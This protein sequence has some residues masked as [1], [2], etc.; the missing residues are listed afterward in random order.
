MSRP[1]AR[2]IKS[3]FQRAL[4]CLEQFGRHEMANHAAAG[5][6]AFLLSALPAL[7]VILY[8]ASLAAGAFAL[9]A[10]GVL[11]LL[12]PYL[13][14]FGGRETLA[15]LLSRPLAGFAGAF[16]LINL[17]WAARLFIVS[18][19]RGIRV[20]Y[21]GSASI[22]PVR[23]NA[24][25]FI[26]E[27]VTLLA[28]IGLLALGQAL[29]AAQALIAWAPMKA[30]VGWLVSAGLVILPAAVLWLFVYATYRNVPPK[31]PARLNALL[32]SLLCIALYLGISAF[33][34]LF[35]DTERYGL[36]Y[37]ILGNL[38]AG[39]IKV[40]SF[41]WFYFFFAE[42]C[43]T[44]EYYDSLLFARFHRLDTADKAPNAL[45]RGLFAKPQRLFR[46][47]AKD[48]R[49]GQ[50]IFTKGQKGD[51]AFY[52]YKGSVAIYLDDPANGAAAVSRVREGEFF[53]EMASILKESRSAWALAE[54]A[55]TVFVLPAAMFERILSQDPEASRRL[56]SIMASRLLANN[57]LLCGGDGR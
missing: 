1:L 33:V 30:V 44:L 3:T 20:V 19:Q 2:V 37:G 6:Y 13:D 40:Y 15:A 53:G 43:Y 9:D 7:L 35:I 42:L 56:V 55:A 10:D 11:R 46:R 38:I 39:L 31:R 47:Y 22:N 14:A 21:A 16:G 12:G 29:R 5:A 51:E 32:S 50:A 17:I 27:L 57:D 25:T 23:E 54:E 18:I 45:E 4:F 34:G 36:L 41:F 52:L 24:L 28:A 26:L 49:P 8:L 48:Y